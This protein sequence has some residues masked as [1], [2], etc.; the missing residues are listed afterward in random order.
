VGQAAEVEL[1]E[2]QAFLQ[3]MRSR[4]YPERIG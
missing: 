1:F 2:N 4:A 3:K